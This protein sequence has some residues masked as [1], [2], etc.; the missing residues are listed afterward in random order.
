MP[1]LPEVETIRSDLDKVLPGK[2]I[3]KVIYD[4]PKM[5]LP[6]PRRLV[7]AVKGQS[8]QSVERAAKMLI[9]RLSG[10]HDL[11][12]HLKM[13]GQLVYRPKQ[14][15]MVVG[16]HPFG[17]EGMA[18][19]NKFTHAIFEFKGGGILY[20]ND[21]RKFGWVK[22]VK[23]AMLNK[24][25]AE[26][27]G[28]E[29]LS[30]SFT[31]EY[32]LGVLRDKSRLKIKQVLLNQQLIAGLGNIYVDEACFGARILPTRVVKTLNDREKV[33]LY[34]EI[35]KVLRRSIKARGTSF[36]TYR[37]GDG[38][39]GN[40][41]KYLKVYKQEGKK[42]QRVD[43]GTIKRTVMNGRGTRYCPACQK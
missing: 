36:D 22:S 1:E 32:F 38:K 37:D 43:G 10:T 40:F 41:V 27:Y 4:V 21:I 18:L 29:P 16:G 42:C 20:F 28:P 25:I 33:A 8:V 39:K 23:R 2:T 9:C 7:Q 15:A 26:S 34:R 11:A 24:L 35:G 17:Y 12:F 19:P 3:I 13:T 6:S 30:G 31:K 5:L 14:G